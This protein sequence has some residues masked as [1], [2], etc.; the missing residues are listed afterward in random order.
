M[1][2]VARWYRSGFTS[3]TAFGRVRFHPDKGHVRALTNCPELA[4][5]SESRGFVVKETLLSRVPVPLVIVGARAGEETTGTR[6]G[7]PY[8]VSRHA[9]THLLFAFSSNA[10]L[11]EIFSVGG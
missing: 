9:M 10:V 3:N 6:R 7:G 8:R 11:F 2:F 1:A 4:I 5:L